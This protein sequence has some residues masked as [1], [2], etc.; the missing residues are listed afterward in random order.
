MKLRRNDVRYPVCAIAADISMQ[1]GL[2]L[3]ELMISM[4]LGLLVIMVATALLLSA[5]TG[6]TLQDEGSRI[7]ET[8]RFALEIV[9]RALHQTAHEN[10]DTDGAPLVTRAE[11]SPNIKGLDASSVKQAVTGIES[12]Q[13]GSVNG[14]DVLALRFYGTGS[15]TNGDGTVVNCAG[16]GVA[17]PA[18]QDAADEGRGW[19]IFYVANSSSGEPELR[20]KYLGKSAW[21]SDA[22]ATG[23]E[24]FQVLYGVDT[25]GDGMPNTYL[26]ATAVEELDASLILDG[27]DAAAQARDKNRKTHWKK[28]AAVK[29]ALLVRASTPAG[30]SAE[31]VRY[32]LFGEDYGDVH[33][34][35]DRGIR[36]K[37]EDLP[38]AIR[39]R[40]RRI[41]VQTIQLRNGSAGGGA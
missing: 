6:Y 17:A 31:K 11:F 18:S 8:G 13:A 12:P 30:V 3:V 23:V 9:T 37:E 33:A 20:C 1:A 21:A 26:N 15:G 35:S 40:A 16:F 25:D 27:V 39:N 34:A 38:Q 2:A 14:S 22:I 32:D 10:W 24:S 19:S 5:K 29:I 36:I 28:V 41:F 4:A 7:E